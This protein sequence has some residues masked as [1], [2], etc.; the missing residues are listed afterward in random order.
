MDICIPHQS[1]E[2]ESEREST[3]KGERERG[4]A[5]L[6]TIRAAEW[7][8]DESGSENQREKQ[9]P[10][11]TQWNSNCIWMPVQWRC[12]PNRWRRGGGGGGGGGGRQRVVGIKGDWLAWQI[13]IVRDKHIHVPPREEWM[14]KAFLL[15][16]V[17]AGEISLAFKAELYWLNLQH[18]IHFHV[19]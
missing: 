3:T 19:G 17:D 15:P 2:W 4:R 11:W 12:W 14:E 13:A 9:R 6:L 16:P 1:N 5:S 8:Q 7:V 18:G 10:S